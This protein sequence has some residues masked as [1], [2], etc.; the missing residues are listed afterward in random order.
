MFGTLTESDAVRLRFGV[1]AAAARADVAAAVA[2]IYA[3]VSAAVDARRPACVA[4]GR[5][6]HFDA[7]GHDL[8]V[9]T[10]ELAAFVRE[11]RA[12]PVA[13]PAGCPFQVG[14]LCGVHA[15]R[16]FGCR[17]FYCDP[18]AQQWQQDLYERLHAD[19]RRLHA[20]MGVDYFYV[21]WRRALA[22]LG[23]DG[24]ASIPPFSDGPEVRLPVG[25][26]PPSLGINP[27]FSLTVSARG[28]F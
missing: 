28:G 7:Y 8:F 25:A 24:R 3:T 26:G 21:E 2:D 12:T 23:L 9:T 18:T 5:C 27:S 1:T 6:C 17:L 19:L 11:L 15:I 16:P 10:L 13:N 20:L 22:A 14:K 4:S